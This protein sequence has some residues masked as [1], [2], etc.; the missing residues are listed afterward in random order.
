MSIPRLHS[1]ETDPAR[2]GRALGS[3]HA[4]RIHEN[5]AAYRLLFDAVGVGESELRPHGEQARDQILAWA[6][7]LHAEIAGLAAGAGAHEWEIAMLNARTEILATVGATAE[8]ECSTAVFIGGPGAPHTIQ[9]W[10][11]HEEMAG[12]RTLVEYTPTPGRTVRAFT[13]AGVLAKIG[14]N[15]SGLGV[16]FN[17]LSHRS[18]GAAIGVPV[19]AIAR[20]VLDLAGTVDEAVDIARSARVSASTV[21]TVVSHDG[22]KSEAASIEIS[23]AGVAVVRPDTDG[24]LIHTNHF[25]DPR[26]ALG[27]SAAAG[28]ST[29]PRYKQLSDRRA[30]ITSAD[31]ADRVALMR[32]HEEEGAPLCCHPKPGLPFHL[33]W[34]TL[35]TASLDLAGHRLRCHSGEP[36]TAT[37]DTWEYL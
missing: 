21:L 35:L 20:R 18:D 7:E 9:T 6:P 15:D 17:I 37:D 5:I 34:R 10:D 27:E 1:D 22:R 25:L 26:L 2:R 23:P 33:Q 28:A 4:G 24:V 3:T 29:H 36:C 32:L 31:P 12:A 14:L 16:H 8:G 19:H 11:W 13:E 30:L